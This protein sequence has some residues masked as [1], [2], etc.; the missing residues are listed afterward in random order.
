MYPRTYASL[1]DC[2]K[3][4]EEADEQDKEVE[5]DDDLHPSNFDD[6][7]RPDEHRSWVRYGTTRF[8][9]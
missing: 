4:T 9:L 8:S 6:P 1:L 5:G 2:L 7:M 3:N